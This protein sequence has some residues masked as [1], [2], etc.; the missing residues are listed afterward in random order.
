VAAL[1]TLGH[2]RSN[3]LAVALVVVLAAKFYCQPIYINNEKSIKLKNT[4]FKNSF[5]TRS[6]PKMVGDMSRV[7]LNFDLSKIP[8]VRF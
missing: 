1:Y 2:A 5:K 7:T 4:I 8:F 6:H 3:D